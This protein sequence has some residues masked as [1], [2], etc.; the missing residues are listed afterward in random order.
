MSL[1]TRFIRDAQNRI[2]GTVVSGYKDDSE[3]VRNWRAG[4]AEVS[5]N[6]MIPAHQSARA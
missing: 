2:R 3:V 4:T 6:L 5:R 1:K